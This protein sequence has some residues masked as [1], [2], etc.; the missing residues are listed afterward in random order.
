MIDPRT[1]LMIFYFIHYF[2]GCSNVHCDFSDACLTIHGVF[3][4]IRT[5]MINSRHSFRGVLHL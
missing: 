4:P 5:V 2:E 3:K 1:L